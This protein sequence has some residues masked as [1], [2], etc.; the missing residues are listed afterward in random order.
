MNEQLVN[1]HTARVGRQ[2]GFHYPTIHYFSTADPATPETEKYAEMAYF[3][4]GTT[5]WNEGDTTYYY[6]RPT[7]GQLL[8]WL[9]LEHNVDICWFPIYPVPKE[10]TG[11]W[12]RIYAAQG[13]NNIIWNPARE[14]YVLNLSEYKFTTLEDALDVAL[15]ACLNLLPDHA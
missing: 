13:P 10:T 12:Y 4:G 11:K 5:D 1:F 15:L 7:Q 2:K 6:S 8:D 9:R 3:N 14:V